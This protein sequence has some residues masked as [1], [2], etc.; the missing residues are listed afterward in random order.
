MTTQLKDWYVLLSV[1]HVLCAKLTR[2]NTSDQV[3]WSKGWDVHSLKTIGQSKDGGKK[4]FEVS[5]AWEEVKEAKAPK[6]RG[7]EE[8][9]QSQGWSSWKELWCIKDHYLRTWIT[10]KKVKT[11]DYVV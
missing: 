5:S 11:Y 8:G 9:L 1:E 2:F 4:N 7:E 3:W 10:T 6:A